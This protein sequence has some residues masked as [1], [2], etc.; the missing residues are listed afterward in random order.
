MK[1]FF[2]YL[3]T[4]NV[5]ITIFDIILCSIIYVLRERIELESQM[6]TFVNLTA[7]CVLMVIFFTAV[8][9]HY[10]RWCYIVSILLVI[11]VFN[12][13]YDEVIFFDTFHFKLSYFLFVSGAV[14]IFAIFYPLIKKISIQIL[15]F[16]ERWGTHRIKEDAQHM[17]KYLEKNKEKY[18]KR[19]DLENNKLGVSEIIESTN[20]EENN[21]ICQKI[22]Y[23]ILFIIIF[24]V[25]LVSL[26]VLLFFVSSSQGSNIMKKVT[27]ENLLN[28]IVSFIGIIML[29]VF[30]VGMIVSMFLKWIEIIIG[31]VTNQNTGKKYFVIA[32]CLFL[33]SQYV[34][35]NYA[36][37]TDDAVDIFLDGKLFTFPLVL[38]ILIPIFLIFAENIVDFSKKNKKIKKQLKKC[39][40]QTINIAVGIV[41]SLLTFVEFVTSDY[42]NTIIEVTEEEFY[43]QE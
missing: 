40:K 35:D 30:V 13:F 6:I 24:S 5:I 9:K 1:K 20:E 26:L 43:N 41:Q 17:Q 11:F 15:S 3:I 21:I 10:F 14:V 28:V 18:I 25:L 36:Y 4:N 8:R 27:S 19:N 42:L 34:F 2:E 22:P 32:C 12:R 16:L 23:S 33:I 29:L 38:S 37:T 7:V 31:I 39:R